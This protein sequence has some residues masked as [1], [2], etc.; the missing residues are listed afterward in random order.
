ME[1]LTICILAYNAEQYIQDTFESLEKQQG[2]YRYLLIVDGSTDNTLAICEEFALN[3]KH[4]IDIK[5]F[6]TNR[7][8]AF[9]RQWAL[10]HTVT[11]YIMF[12]DS[13][14]IATSNLVND[15]Y[16]ALQA[17]EMC[18][19]VSC[20]ASYIDENGQKLPGGM[21]FKMSDTHA[22][23]ERA[24]EGKLIFMLPATMFRREYALKA[25]GYRQAGFPDGLIRYQDLSEDLDLWSRM[26]DFYSDGKYMKILPK[27]LYYYRKRTGSL[28][29]SKCTQYAMSLKIKFIKHNLKR[30][31]AGENEIEFTDFLSN[32][33]VWEKFHDKRQFYSEYFYRKAA[34]AFAEHKYFRAVL[35]LPASILLNPKYLID[36]FHAN[37]L[38]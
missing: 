24:S 4:P 19:A 21:Y 12:F 18:I 3:T 31:R 7:G 15:L 32:R 25:G 35:N 1:K 14:D 36:K 38:G 10:E 29:S 23:I 20:Q 11:E 2:Q 30:R 13:D 17:D 5:E 9:C 22:F 27:V 16:S 28:S 37:I 34:F 8:T 26:S 33:T 6:T